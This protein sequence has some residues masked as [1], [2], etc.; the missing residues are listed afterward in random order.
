MFGVIRPLCFLCCFILDSAI[1]I[2][3]P[4]DLYARLQGDIMIGG[5]FPI[6]KEISDLAICTE[7]SELICTGF[8]LR[9]FL[10]SLGMVHAIERINSF[11]LLPGIKLGY[12]IYDTCGDASRGLQETIRFTGYEELAYEIL[13]GMCNVTDLLPLVKA[14]VGA[15]YSEVSVAVARLLGF[16]LV[17]QISYGSTAAILSDKRRFPSF[18]RT[19]PSDVHMT[20]ALAKLIRIFKWSYVGII[21]SDDDYGRSV[22][23]SLSMQFDSKYVC[24]AFKEKLPADISKPGVHVAIKTV[25]DTIK[26]SPAEVV[27]LALKV[28]VV[29]ELFNEIIKKNITRLWIATDYWSTSREVAAMPDI[30]SV[31]N[32]LGLSFKNIEVPGF[33]I[34]LRNLTV[35]P[36]ATNVFIEEYKRLR[37]ECTDEYKEYKH[38]LKASPR[39]CTKSQSLKFKSPLA[40][41]TEN[42]ALASDDYL[43]K[44]IELDGTYSAYLSVTA[45]A[46]ALNNILCSNGICNHNMTFAP[47]QLHKTSIQSPVQMWPAE[48]CNL[49]QWIVLNLYV[50][51]LQLLKEL[52]KIEFYD[53]D[54]KIFF[55][56]DGNANIGYD[57]VSWYTVN[58]SME[59]HVVGNYELSNGSIYLNKSLIIWNTE[60]KKAPSSLCTKP[61]IPGQYKIHSDVHCCY[62]CS[63]CAEGYYS[64]SYDMTECKKCPYDQWSNKGSAYCENR[65]IE[66]LEWTNP[67]AVVLCG[68]ALI[69]FVI[70]V[71]VGIGF[72][73]HVASP[74]VKAAGGIYIC[75]MNFSLLISFAN[76]ILFIGEP[77]NVS[78][79]IRQP[80]FGVSFTLCVSCILIKSF[81]IVLAFEMGNKFQ[82]SIRITYQP[83]IVVIVLTAFQVCICTLWLLLRG[84]CIKN[85]VLIPQTLIVQ[86]DEGST[87]GYAIMLG[88]IGFLAFV[89]FVLAYRGRNLPDKYNESRCITFSMLIY[90]FVWFAFIPVYVTTNG[91][92]LPAVEMVAIL[93]SNYGVLGSHLIPTCYII[94]FKKDNNKREKYLESIQSFS[95]VKCAVDYHVPEISRSQYQ[96]KQL[97]FVHRMRKRC[98]SV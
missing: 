72:L 86:C 12:E 13:H 91:M 28:P 56:D 73:Q 84:P 94:F 1:P 53:Y 44:N 39:N 59:F 70:V 51:P 2:N 81:R 76:S 90:L 47:W 60:D 87:I 55:T 5:L 45:I 33:R 68:F 48:S 92:Y 43:D 58:G 6:H 3:S 78:C 38:C 61:C 31:G 14:V 54:E 75:V 98:K 82:H 40:C 83:A 69:G 26:Q 93:A 29:M 74:A 79:K 24:T 23:E 30:D 10:R 71:I 77:R 22:L 7:P 65:T 18:L 11:N 8:D 49:A 66:Y 96:A 36:N 4:N 67:F 52:K 80:L 32:I 19:V 64:E 37:F 41:S 34:Y 46:K 62:N 88:Y 35:G 20:K 97:C 85:I 21:S 42:I 63:D 95:K 25:T 50:F 9:G 16:Q 15:G 89:C 57:V 17:P 27:I